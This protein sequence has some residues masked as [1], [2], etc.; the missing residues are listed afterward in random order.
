MQEILSMSD[1]TPHSVSPYLVC[2]NARQAIAFYQQAFGAEQLLV[3]NTADGGIL[4][5][6]LKI[7]GSSMMLTEQN[8]ES[9][10][11]SHMSLSDSPVTIHLVV[12]DVDAVMHKAQQAG[13]TVIMEPA[14]RFWGDRFACLKDP[15]G[16]TWSLAT[17]L[18][19]MS[20]AEIQQA[21]NSM[22]ASK[23]ED[24]NNL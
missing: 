13:A 23:A 14:E 9:Q 2:A 7:N 8:P 3:I 4:H 16:H 17:P 20:E 10:G 24:E 5:A 15:F 22:M 21:A 18:R 11:I 1:F 6:T 19:N 12:D